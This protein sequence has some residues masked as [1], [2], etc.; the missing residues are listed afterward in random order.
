[1]KKIKFGIIGTS[2]ITENF[3]NAAKSIVDFELVSIY[4]RDL[5]KAKSFG[6]KFGAT[7]FFDDLNSFANSSAFDAVYI[8]S[9]N[10]LHKKQSIA[11]LNGGKHVLCE[12]AIG[13]N[14]KEVLEM[15]STAKEKNLVLMEAM[16]ITCL[17]NFLEVK[18]A[19]SKIGIVRKVFFSYCQYSS[20][21]DNFKKGIIENAFKR[22]ISTGA[23]SDIGIY[24]VHPLVN[25]FGVP[26]S[27]HAT[28]EV[29]H[30]GTDGSGV[31]IF[32]YDN[33]DATIIYSKISNSYLPC[34]IQGENGTILIDS[35]RFNNIKIIYRDGSTEDITIPQ[36]ENDMCYEIESFIQT[37]LSKSTE[38]SLNPLSQSL[39]SIKI[40]DTIRKSLGIVYD[41]D[42]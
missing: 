22:E 40:I 19:L 24:C 6:A 28:G 8:A 33:M 29:L 23:L 16:R 11:M 3:L 2:S 4:S 15:I 14:E 26:H 37:I 25:L 12:K 31:A 36:I 18:K 1:M 34:E 13:S 9:P 32:K 35:I 10:F 5:E 30:T 39:E 38:S 41:S 17:P 21:Y 20:R 27:I 7:L 42:L